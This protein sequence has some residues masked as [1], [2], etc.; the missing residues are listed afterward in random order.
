MRNANPSHVEDSS[1]NAKTLILNERNVP[2]L[3]LMSILLMKKLV[4]GRD[5]SPRSYLC[6]RRQG[7]DGTL[8]L[9]VDADGRVSQTVVVFAVSFPVAVLRADT[10]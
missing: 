4:T 5:S 6:F 8:L 7:R 1:H 9:P 2:F 10:R 3:A